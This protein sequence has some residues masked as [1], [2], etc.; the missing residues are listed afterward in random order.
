MA[1]DHSP[2]L[3]CTYYFCFTTA[4]V[5]IPPEVLLLLPLAVKFRIWLFS[6]P[7]VTVEISRQVYLILGN[8]LSEIPELSS[9]TP[10]TTLLVV[11]T[12]L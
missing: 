12:S 4:L 1:P 10:L 11:Q 6:L 7:R 3:C 8:V 2:S 9:G 5:D